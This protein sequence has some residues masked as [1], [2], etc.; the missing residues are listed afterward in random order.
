MWLIYRLFFRFRNALDKLHITILVFKFSH[1]FP[2][3]SIFTYFNNIKPLRLYSTISRP[4]L[5]SDF[6]LT[7]RW[8]V[9]KVCNT[10]YSNQN[11]SWSGMVWF[12]MVWDVSIR[13]H[14]KWLQILLLSKMRQKMIEKNGS[15][16]MLPKI[17][18]PKK[19]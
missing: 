12:L 2:A 3:Q 10:A 4:K 16:R 6:Y 18:F 19:S 14:L 17:W 15:E 1:I 7:L 13:M 9:S 8:T 5:S 11:I